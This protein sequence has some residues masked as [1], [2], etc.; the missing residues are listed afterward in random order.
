MFI[1]SLLLLQLVQANCS[2]VAAV[3]DPAK[4]E[5]VFQSIGGD[6][7]IEAALFLCVVD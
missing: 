6:V 7:A 4:A 2:A 1:Y 5:D 3:R